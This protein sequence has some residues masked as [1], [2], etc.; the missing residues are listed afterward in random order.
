MFATV[1]PP[2]L[3]T[4]W[5]GETMPNPVLIRVN[6]AGTGDR[7]CYLSGVEILA[8]G[9]TVQ[10]NLMADFGCE[11]TFEVGSTYEIR[12]GSVPVQAASCAGNP[13]CP[14][15]AMEPFAE[16]AKPAPPRPSVVFREGR[17]STT[18]AGFLS[19]GES[20]GHH[21]FEGREG[22]SVTIAIVSV[23]SS[24][25]FS[26]KMKTEEEWVTVGQGTSWRGVLPSAESNLYQIEVTVPAG[27]DTYELFVGLGK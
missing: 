12:W 20:V 11:H 6:S 13:D 26:L 10:R 23:Y 14:D 8:D 4:A 17:M 5:A 7:G 3:S 21:S 16:S 19:P 18:V 2:L 22:Q 15:F 1:I 27:E 24:A 9:S 25:V